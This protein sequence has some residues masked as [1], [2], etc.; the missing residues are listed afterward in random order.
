MSTIMQK[1]GSNKAQA[2]Q[3]QSEIRKSAE[4]TEQ[5]KRIMIK[6]SGFASQEAKLESTMAKITCPAFTKRD[7][8]SPWTILPKLA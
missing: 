6:D 3:K 7:V 2:T 1:Y 4:K 8:H 5:Q